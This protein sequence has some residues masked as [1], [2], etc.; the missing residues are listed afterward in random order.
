MNEIKFS[1]SP[2]TKRTT[3]MHEGLSIVTL[4]SYEKLTKD[5]PALIEEGSDKEDP[6]DD[7][8]EGALTSEK[9]TA[10]YQ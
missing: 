1:K 8:Y 4:P 2:G 3:E 7:I 5:L 9:T 6:C 10:I